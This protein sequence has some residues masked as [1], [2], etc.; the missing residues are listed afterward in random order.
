[1]IAAENYYSY[2]TLMT[3][4]S[5]ILLILYLIFNK[6]TNDRSYIVTPYMIGMS[7]FLIIT[8]FLAT[9]PISG[10]FGD[11]I[12]YY[13]L[14]E[15]YI[16]A[17]AINENGDFLFE[18]MLFFFAKNF[19]AESF[20]FFCTLLY[21]IPLYL[22]YKKVFK[23]LWPIAFV[24]TTV[25]ISF[26]GFAVNGIRNGIAAQIF[27]L[28]LVLPK[29]ISWSLI[30]ISIGLHSS[31]LIPAIGYFSAILLKDI[32]FYF[33][34]WS[35]A[36]LISF[37]YSGFGDIIQSLGFSNDRLDV[38]I[39]GNDA[40]LD[41]FSVQ[42]YRYDFIMYGAFPVLLGA[43][44][45][46]KRNFND[47]FYNHLL[48]VYLFSNAIFLLMNEVLFSNRFAYLSWFMMVLIL[49]Y[50]FYKLRGKKDV[51]ILILSTLFLLVSSLIVA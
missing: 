23:S 37:F 42:G 24:L 49:F 39:D 6:N 50:P 8:L 19:S 14:F 46:Y 41:T 51:N 11:M 34:F 26:Y 22:A 9:R 13:I 48:S 33:G 36:L 3:T 40:L 43:Y 25:T 32:R 44:Y 30:I 38:Y 1:M 29:R 16:H 12:S 18:L 28:G 5:V 35:V 47:S 4:L 2:Y 17:E 7:A 20:F 45:I 15:Q 21:F 10:Y 31:M 27:L